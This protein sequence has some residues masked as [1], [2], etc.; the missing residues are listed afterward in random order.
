MHIKKS[1][2]S[3]VTALFVTVFLQGCL[4]EDKL[5]IK[6]QSNVKLSQTDFNSLS[7]WEK[8]DHKKA[9]QSFLHSCRKFS[10]MAQNRVIGNQIVQL[11]ADDFRDVCELAEVVKTMNSKQTQNFFENWFRPFLVSDKNSNSNGLFT[12]YYEASL[13]GSKVKDEKYKY[14]VF[15]KPK[16]IDGI[17]PYFTR[18]EIEN[19]ALENRGL[20]LFY[21]D[22]KVEL[23]FAHIQGSGR[24]K[25][26]SGAEVRISF[27]GRNNHP[28]IAISNYMAENGLIERENMSA[29]SVKEWLKNNPEKADEVMNINPAY[30]FFKI[31]DDENVVGA[32]GVALTPEHSLAVDDGIIPYGLPLWVETSLKKKD[33]SRKNYEKLFIA[34]D[35]G[36]AIR[37][38]VR[39][40]I[41]FGYGKEAEEK[42]Y[43][44]A[45]RGKYYALLPVNVVDKILVI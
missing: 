17:E 35:T 1:F 40:D 45:S 27:A 26:P 12:G 2:F 29:A 23:F 7:N 14:P 36:S 21:V 5:I 31:S 38:A 8:E 19:G 41:F 42:A 16:D 33:G 24:I 32:Q 15:A 6:G 9:L 39:G 3:V 44:M 28:F 22:D 4:L 18:S 20:E 34:Q 25:L 30:I 11:T 43:Y 10:K 13:N 37:G